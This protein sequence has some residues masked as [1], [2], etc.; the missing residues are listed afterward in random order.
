V[1]ATVLPTATQAPATKTPTATVPPTPVEPLP[2]ARTACAGG[3]DLTGQTVSFYHILDPHDQVDTVYNPLRA[4]Y[5]D[6]TEYFNLHGGICGATLEQ[7]IDDKHWGAEQTIYNLYKVLDPKPTVMLLYG[8]NM[9]VMLADQLAAAQIPALNIRGGS[10]TSAYGRDGQ[11]LGW[12]FATRPLYTDQ[13]GAMC[14]YIIANPERYP[15]PVM[16]FLNFE[17]TWAES[18][19]VEAHPY[20]GSLGIGDAGVI[21]FSSDDTVSIIGQKVQKLVDAGANIIYTNSHENGPALIARALRDMG[22]QDKVT[23]ATLNVAMDPYVAF[24]GEANLGADGLPAIHGMLGSMPVRSLA[25]TDNPGIQ[26]IRSQADLHQRPLTMRTDGYIMGW[27]TTDL[28]I[29]VYIQTINRVGFEHVTGAEIKKTLENI[30]YAPLGGVEQIDYQGGKRRALA[31]DRIGEMEYLGQDG[32]TPAGPGNPPMVVTEGDQ[33]HLVPMIIPLTDYLPAPDLRPG[34]ADVPPASEISPT[35]ASTAAATSLKKKPTPT[36]TATSAAQTPIPTTSGVVLGTVTGRIAF[37]T[38]RDGNLEIYVMNGDGSGLT[39]LTNNQ[40]NDGQP[41][42]SPD[43]RK[44]LFVSDRDSNDEIYVM[45]A[46]GS[47]PTNLTDNPSQDDTADWSPDGKKIVF[48]SDRDGK[49]EIYVMNADGSGQT[50]LTDDPVSQDYFPIW[51]QDGK[52]I[53]FTS[54]R[55]GGD[56]NIYVM[57]ADGSNQTRLTQG[58]GEDTFP[59]WSPDGKKIV[60]TS[61]RGGGMWDNILGNGS[62]EIYVM[63]AD[64]SHRTQLTDNPG[65]DNLDPRWSPNGTQIIFWSSRDGNKELYVMNADGSHQTRLTNTTPSN[66]SW[67][68]WH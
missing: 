60:Y 6:A 25:E 2:F 39:N 63:N 68:S 11:T 48:M 54:E 7:V 59:H 61:G 57:N 3:V 35:S 24:S 43:G 8:S 45:N 10:T 41:V 5:A 16:G 21:T 46:D 34:G 67:A 19:T 4:G 18:A 47:D 37:Q 27:D 17:D 64:G 51:S 33:K 66:S 29:E 65:D 26:L 15:R 14:D 40:A 53:G 23:L 50:K 9:A 31:A 42:W 28:L 30:V 32:K 1:P 55:K 12:V 56:G 36:A 58:S 62:Y 20:C 44:I 52:Q 13:V 49:S 22:L 38:N